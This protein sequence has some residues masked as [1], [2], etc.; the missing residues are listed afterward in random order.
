MRRHGGINII[1]FNFIFATIIFAIIIGG[2]LHENSA[3]YSLTM[4]IEKSSEEERGTIILFTQLCGLQSVGKCDCALYTGGQLLRGTERLL[5]IF[6]PAAYQGTLCD[7]P[8][9]MYRP[10][11]KDYR[12]DPTHITFRARDECVVI[13]IES[14]RGPGKTIYAN[15]NPSRST[16]KGKSMRS[17]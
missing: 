1:L 14:R 8:S 17:D 10:I 4:K 12:F 3:P 5:L 11:K 6:A 2:L 15:G 13:A 7:I 16:M 9:K